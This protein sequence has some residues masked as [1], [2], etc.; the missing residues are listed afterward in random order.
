MS[1]QLNHTLNR[2]LYTVIL[3]GAFSLLCIIIANKIASYQKKQKEKTLDFIAKMLHENDIEIFCCCDLGGCGCENFAK[4]LNDS[5]HAMLAESKKTSIQNFHSLYKSQD[6][7]TKKIDNSE[8]R[9]KHSVFGNKSTLKKTFI[10]TGCLASN[11]K[12]LFF[13]KKKIRQASPLI[14]CLVIA[15]VYSSAILDKFFF[16]NPSLDT[17]DLGIV[18]TGLSPKSSAPWIGTPTLLADIAHN[19]AIYQSETPQELFIRIDLWP[20]YIDNNRTTVILH[21]TTSTSYQTQ[22]EIKIFNRL[23]PATLLDLITKMITNGGTIY[24]CTPS[25]LM[26][27]LQAFEAITTDGNKVHSDFKAIILN[28]EIKA[29]DIDFFKQLYSRYLTKHLNQSMLFPSDLSM[30][31]K[32]FFRPSTKAF[33][34]FSKRLSTQDPGELQRIKIV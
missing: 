5:L 15:P 32:N 13:L 30:L 27:I 26:I 25:I 22:P 7:L 23:A 19:E 2:L 4:N 21:P 12:F 28:D 6:T 18:L 9:L 29:I 34:E 10:F 31:H 11:I 33:E 14:N 16:D 8:T 20:N 1:N 24:F 17:A 3:T